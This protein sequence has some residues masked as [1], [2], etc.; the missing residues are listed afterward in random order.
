MAQPQLA[1]TTAT[2]GHT[3]TGD[4]ATEEEEEKE[5]TFLERNFF[6][7]KNYNLS[8]D[9]RRIKRILS[10]MIFR[11]QEAFREQKISLL[12]KITEIKSSTRKLEYKIEEISLKL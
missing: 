6:L 2:W 12:K 1:Q 7:K 4:F 9:K 11:I 3:R 5:E 10:F 8:S